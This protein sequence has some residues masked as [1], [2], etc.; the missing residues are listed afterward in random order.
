MRIPFTM[1]QAADAAALSTETRRGH[2][3][4]DWIARWAERGVQV[5]LHTLRG[6][7]QISMVLPEETRDYL[8]REAARLGEETGRQWSRAAVIRALWQQEGSP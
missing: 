6:T 1:Y 2:V 3:L 4:R 5:D 7:K 8:D